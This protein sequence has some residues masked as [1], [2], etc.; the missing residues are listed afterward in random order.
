MLV[1]LIKRWFKH[2]ISEPK[3]AL[4]T[5]ELTDKSLLVVD[6]PNIEP[7][8][9]RSALAQMKTLSNDVVIKI[10][11]PL[12]KK[13]REE[14]R[15]TVEDLKCSFY[16]IPVYVEGK[17][18]SDSYLSLETVKDCLRD[19]YAYVGIA[20]SDTDFLHLA[21]FLLTTTECKP[22]MFIDERKCNGSVLRLLGKAFI[23]TPIGYEMKYYSAKPKL[24]KRKAKL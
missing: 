15:S 12:S 24:R 1:G 10:Y 18:S 17:V 6:A 2:F 3:Q 19:N 22:I 21:N 20:S 14:W 9:L 5:Q 11:A 8:D 16:T 4:T 7:S 13:L 23:K